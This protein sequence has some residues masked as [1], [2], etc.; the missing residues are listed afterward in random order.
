MRKPDDGDDERPIRHRSN[1]N[2]GTRTPAGDVIGV[3]P[4]TDRQRLTTE[5][6]ATSA[7]LR[8]RLRLY[9]YQ[10]DPAEFDLREW[11]LHRVDPRPGAI[12]VDVG[13]GPGRYLSAIAKRD[14]SATAIGFDLSA[15]MAAE[16]AAH[17]PVG[18]ADAIALPV[19]D[20]STDVLLAAHMLYHV[21]DMRFAIAEFARIVRTDG[22]VA[23]VLNGD[24]HLPEMYA[25]LGAAV[26]RAGGPPGLRERTFQRAVLDAAAPLVA[27]HFADVQRAET[28]GAIVVPDAAPV[29]AYL[30]SLRSLYDDLP[31]EWNAV[32]DAGT[33]LVTATIARNGAWRTQSHVGV[34]LARMPV[35]SSGR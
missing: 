25:L 31:V 1:R 13:C 20:R 4:R 28:T 8:Q 5:A 22:T 15:G 7:P 18:V 11:V 6:Y 29:V 3:D 33:Q 32:L 2:A 10:V 24:H 30:D 21:A 35:P 26:R 27:D 9:D 14:A 12:V 16:A 34:L 19:P 17:G 23:I